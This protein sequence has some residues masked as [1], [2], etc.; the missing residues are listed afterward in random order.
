MPR[1]VIWILIHKD[2]NESINMLNTSIASIYLRYECGPLKALTKIYWNILAGKQGNMQFTNG[3]V[4]FL[5]HY[6]ENYLIA[7]IIT[8]KRIKMKSRELVNDL[9]K[10]KKVFM[11]SKVRRHINEKLKNWICMSKNW[12]IMKC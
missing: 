5:D 4:F 12:N 6:D 8:D 7:L 10:T 3:L 11:V 1:V 2:E 9:M